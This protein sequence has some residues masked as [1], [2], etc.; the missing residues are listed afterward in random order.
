[1]NGSASSSNGEQ[2]P[3]N[4]EMFVVYLLESGR[5]KQHGGPYPQADSREI[6]DDMRRHVENGNHQMWSIPENTSHIVAVTE[7]VLW[8]IK[9]RYHER[10]ATDGGFGEVC[11]ECGRHIVKAGHSPDCSRNDNDDDDDSHEDAE[12]EMP[13]GTATSTDDDCE[14]EFSE[15]DIVRE[16]SDVTVDGFGPGKTEYKVK[17][18]LRDE[19]GSKRYYYLETDEGEYLCNAKIIEHSYEEITESESRVWPKG[20][21]DGMLD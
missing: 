10:V 6:R 20:N 8:D 5:P 9:K 2:Q 3:I 18:L 19:S 4:P 7:S 15:G 1:M 12:V 11:G 13:S 17:K 14:W 16:Q 21:G